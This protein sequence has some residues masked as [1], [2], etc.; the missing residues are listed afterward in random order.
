MKIVSDII[1]S[2]L[3][4]T[5]LISCSATFFYLSRA[6]LDNAYIDYPATTV[7]VVCGYLGCLTTGYFIGKRGNQ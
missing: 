4:F 7:I 2:I 1:V 3:M 5:G 6:V